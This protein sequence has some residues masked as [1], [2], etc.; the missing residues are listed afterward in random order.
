MYSDLNIFLNALRDSINNDPNQFNR[1][2]TDSMYDAFRPQVDALLN[3]MYQEVKKNAEKEYRN[4]DYAT[5]KMKKWFNSDYSSS[6]DEEKYK[7]ILNNIMDAKSKIK[8]CSYPGYVE[9]LEIMDITNKAIEEIQS[10]IKE[11]FEY[12]RNSQNQISNELNNTLNEINE[13]MPELYDGLQTIK[14]SV[15]STKFNDVVKNVY[16]Q[17]KTFQLITE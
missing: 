3:E 14:K 5:Q 15:K 6:D 1:A 16:G 4:L 2:K 13:Y 10:S 12:L 17:L 7:S 8:T 9:A 11:K